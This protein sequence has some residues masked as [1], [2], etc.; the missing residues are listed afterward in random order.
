MD[1]LLF[2]SVK[3]SCFK[4]FQYFFTNKFNFKRF[5]PG[6]VVFDPFASEFNTL[7]QL[8]LLRFVSINK[9]EMTFQYNK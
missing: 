8:V 3:L 1:P 9:F 4:L 6:T 7:F 5:C 2:E